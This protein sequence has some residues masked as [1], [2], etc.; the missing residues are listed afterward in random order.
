MTDTPSAHAGLIARLR[1]AA[2]H[3]V[4]YGAGGGSKDSSSYRYETPSKVQIQL[5]LL[6]EAADA[7]AAADADIAQARRDALEE[8]AKV[9]ANNHGM[10]AARAIRALIEKQP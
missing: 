3:V 2:V 4:T 7:L 1:A 6:A 10:Y 8:A 5:P 9:V